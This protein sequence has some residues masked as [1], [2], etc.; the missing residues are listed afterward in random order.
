MA[1]KEKVREDVMAGEAPEGRPQMCILIQCR[2]YP[3][4]EAWSNT[5]VEY[6]EFLDNMKSTTSDLTST[7]QLTSETKNRKHHVPG[8]HSEGRQERPQEYP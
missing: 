7:E 6:C 5:C 1:S 3:S 2:S 4:R 8:S